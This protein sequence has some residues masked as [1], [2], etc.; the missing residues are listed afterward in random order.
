MAAIHPTATPCGLREID[1]ATRSPEPATS[2]RNS[3]SVN[4]RRSALLATLVPF[5]DILE[6]IEFDPLATFQPV[7]E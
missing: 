2:L 5:G 6:R 4:A 7:Q 3:S 1:D